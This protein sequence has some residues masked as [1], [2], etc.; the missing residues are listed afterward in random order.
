MHRCQAI[1]ASYDTQLASQIYSSLHNYV[2][3][4]KLT[5]MEY[6]IKHTTEL[7]LLGY[8]KVESMPLKFLSSGL[9]YAN[10]SQKGIISLLS[11]YFALYVPSEISLLVDSTKI[12][13][14]L[15]KIKG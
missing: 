7:Q 1:Y 6:C 9:N 10:I 12:K 11:S 2:N 3:G 15:Q 13:H 4:M 8:Y 14:N 5:L